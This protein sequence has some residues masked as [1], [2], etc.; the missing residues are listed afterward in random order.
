MFD[1]M[2]IME[3]LLIQKNI[4]IIVILQEI[5]Y[6]LMSGL[7]VHGVYLLYQQGLILHMQFQQLLILI[8]KKKVQQ[9]I[10]HLQDLVKKEDI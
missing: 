1:M 10:M 4:K 9:K 5:Q 8:P 7:M 3:Q 2:E 6:L